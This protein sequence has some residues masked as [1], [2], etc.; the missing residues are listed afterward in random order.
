MISFASDSA[1]RR[2]ATGAMPNSQRRPEPSRWQR[3]NLW[4]HVQSDALHLAP[5]GYLQAIVWRARGL[6]VRSRNRLS[7]LTGHSR[8]AY[9]FWIACREPQIRSALDCTRSGDAPTIVPVI[10]CSGA[11]ARKLA[12]S[13]A[14]LPAGAEAIVLGA[15]PMANVRQVARIGE[16]ADQL[17]EAEVWLCPIAS[18]DRLAD[19]ALDAY[20]AVAGASGSSIVYADD[21]LL[22]ASGN[23]VDPHFKPDWNPELFEHHDFLTGAS[24]IK[25]HRDEL[26]GLPEQGWAE[27]LVAERVRSQANPVHI[28]MVL[29][30]RLDRP[31]PVVPAKPPEI[32][33]KAQWPTVTVIEP[34]RNRADLLR[35][36]VEG[37]RQTRYP[38]I[39]IVIVDNESDDP[40]TVDFLFEL[41]ASGAKVIRAP[42][43]FNYSRLNNQAVSLATG[44]LLCFLNNDVE[45][46]D[47]DWLR[48]LVLQ[49]ARPDIGAAGAMLLYPDRTIQH[50]GVFTG[51]GGGAGHGH[52]YLGMDEPGYFERSHIP[53]RVSAVTGACLVVA[54]EK[55][56]AV[57][58]FDEENFPVAFN[59]V[60]LCLKL[61]ERGWQAFYEPRAKL[62]H[63]ESKSRGSDRLKGNRGRFARELQTL[64]VKWHTDERRDPFHHPQLSSFCEQFLI[65]I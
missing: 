39:E 23:R 32:E 47:P 26:Q 49:A 42:G 52:R 18:G 14:S 19:E 22:D 25:V 1:E 61:N 15:P 11:G 6:K 28:P 35:K 51:I 12:D 43:P 29:H 38:R 55:F 48:L 60:D 20:A 36:C 7:A 2:A 62:I 53:Q 58:G 46:I 56:L 24:V 41:E 27:A 65:A 50:A 4:L 33:S 59:D 57:G 16:L 34:T 54:R 5:L 9:P 64:K 13:L 30:H 3:L 40:Q 63:H 45:M 21:D 17:H 10:D 8:W 44:E 37:I 31:K